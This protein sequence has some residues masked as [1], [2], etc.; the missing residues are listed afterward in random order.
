MPTR[1]W[2]Y[3]RGAYHTKSLVLINS[4]MIIENGLE[5]FLYFGS[6]HWLTLLVEGCFSESGRGAVYEPLEI[7]RSNWPFQI[8]ASVSEL[9]KIIYYPLKDNFA[10]RSCAKMTMSRTVYM[11]KALL[12]RSI[13]VEGSKGYFR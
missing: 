4:E 8:S 7:L 10:E 3:V 11:S 12:S 6:I 9:F 5:A 2:S 13:F 1:V